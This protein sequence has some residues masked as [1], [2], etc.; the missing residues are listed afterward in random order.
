MTRRLS[1]CSTLFVLVSPSSHHKQSLSGDG[2]EMLCELDSRP[3]VAF[4]AA[5]PR[6]IQRPATA[7]GIRLVEPLTWLS[8]IRL[9]ASPTATGTTTALTSLD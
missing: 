3:P 9:S 5:L 8:R 7:S 1:C 6:I 4:L 2:Q